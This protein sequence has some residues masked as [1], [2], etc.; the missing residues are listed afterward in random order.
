MKA[1][2]LRNFYYLNTSIIDDYISSI[3]GSLVQTEDVSERVATDKGI[4]AGAGA[5]S[6]KVDAGIKAQIEKETKR[7]LVQTYAGKFQKIYTFLDSENE[8]VPFYDY[9]DEE[10]WSNISR[11]QFLE[12]DVTIRFSKIETIIGSLGTILPFFNQLK[13]DNGTA[14]MDPETQNTINIIQLFREA[15][16]TNGLPAE[17]SFINPGK[18]KLITYFDENSFISEQDKLPKEVTIFAKVQRKLRESE[19]VNL[20]NIIPVLEKLAFNREMKR[21][22]KH[23]MEELPE[24]LM[25]NVKGPGAILIPIAIY[26]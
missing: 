24:E 25:D 13:N 5:F 10:S 18:Y 1:S 7:I 20:T 22:I 19:K 14:L 4:S 8:G 3:D 17:L 23:S 12:I 9:M 11:N 2:A 26:N 6:I 15:N 16:N 21:S